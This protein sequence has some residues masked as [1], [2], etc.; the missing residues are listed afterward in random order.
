M[1]NVENALNKILTSILEEVFNKI[2]PESLAQAFKSNTGDRGTS[3]TGP[4]PQSLIGYYHEDLGPG[5]CKGFFGEVSTDELINGEE[6]AD[7][8]DL[9]AGTAHN[10]DA[11]WLKFLLDGKILFVSKRTYRYGISWDDLHAANVVYGNR[12]VEIDGL[13]YRIRLLK[14]A[15][16]ADF[17]YGHG[18]SGTLQSE[19]IRL[20]YNV[21][22]DSATYP[23][24]GQIGE[25]W[26]EYDQSDAVG[27]LNISAGNGRA[28]WCQETASN[29]ANHRVCCGGY[30]VTYPGF[31]S[32][33]SDG[34]SSGWRIALELVSNKPK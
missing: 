25:N 3:N 20:M 8:V 13:Q 29:V 19:W 2:N 26:A 5:T 32:S 17:D 21:S 10:S 7:I 24:T 18:P 15:D 14:G 28:S 11:P 4:G 12:I 34:T 27:G 16:P 23:K 30:S 33:S 1:K 9:T 22:K 31:Y 6:L